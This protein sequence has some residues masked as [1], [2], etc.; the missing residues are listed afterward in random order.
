MKKVEDLF[1]ANAS[2]PLDLAMLYS[3]RVGFLIP[4]YQRQYDWS[5][6]NIT[7]LFCDSLNGLRRL[8][9][10]T[11]ASAFTFLGTLILVEEDTQ[12]PDFSGVSVAIVDGQQ[13]LTTLALFAC[14]LCEAL[15]RECNNADFSSVK[16]RTRDWLTTEA[17]KRLFALYECAVGALRVSPTENVP[18]P[19]SYAPETLVQP[20]RRARSMCRP[21]AGFSSGLLIIFWKMVIKM[22]M[23]TCRRI[24][25]VVPL[26]RS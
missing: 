20:L 8:A 13:R 1:R 19:K 16:K 12:E 21:L 11:G 24:S 25:G 7:R 4:E 26:L 6:Q 23:N 9:D 3:G 10:N 2:N 17:K 18:F 15:H 22:D 5:E 14:A